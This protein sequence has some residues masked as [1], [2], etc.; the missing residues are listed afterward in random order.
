MAKFEGTNHSAI[1]NSLARTIADARP[2]LESEAMDLAL[3]I[4]P[5]PKQ[6]LT[7]DAQ[8]DIIGE[9][10]PWA[11]VRHPDMREVIADRL[12]RIAEV[13]NDHHMETSLVEKYTSAA[14]RLAHASSTREPI[15]DD[16][17]FAFA[18]DPLGLGPK[19][20]A[21]FLQPQRPSD[22]FSI[23]NRQED[24][25]MVGR[26]LAAVCSTGS[27]DLGVN[28][29]QEPL[30]S[31]MA[32]LVAATK[33]ATILKPI[34]EWF[35]NSDP[36]MCEV[37]QKRVFSLGGSPTLD[38]LGA[39]WGLSRER[40]RQI[41]VMAK[42]LIGLE[43]G[44]LL[45]EASSIFEPLMHK[46]FPLER[47]LTAT[48]LIGI[49]TT[50][51]DEVAGA[52]VWAAGPW[53][54]NDGWIYHKSLETVFRN[55]TLALRESVDPYG[56]VGEDISVL[57]NGFFVTD[58]DQRQYLEEVMGLVEISGY[59]STRD[60][61]RS[62]VA[63]ALMR[64]G[65]PATKGEIGLLAG[66]EEE[67]RVSSYLSMLPNIVRADKDRWAFTDWVDDAYDGIVGEIN[68]RID[69]NHGSVA[70]ASLLYELP[71][72]F[73]VSE[74]SVQA[75][76]QTSAY[77]VE[78]GFV[79]RAEYGFFEA[80]SPTKWP[81]AFQFQNLW[82]QRVRIEQRHFE[83]FSLKV[84]FDIAYANGLRPHCDLKV[85]LDGD[86]AL[87]S[88]IWRTHDVTRSIDVG[89]V[90]DALVARG[91]RPNDLILVCPSPT[92]VLLEKW[93]TVGHL[94]QDEPVV[95]EP[96]DHHDPLFDLLEGE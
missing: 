89:R 70:V 18:V 10:N 7:A 20:S 59:W 60:S 78:D 33:L 81:D 35:E 37:L 80:S 40:V 55:A 17:V 90:S 86:G 58:N 83:G 73:G 38:T 68:Q 66:I 32:F 93:E 84:R 82:G 45:R 43:C 31:S 44:P 63:A 39:P 23:T 94:D 22:D 72:R 3:G 79:R 1:R 36:R 41:E 53:V 16:D 95:Q 47:F 42:K 85:P 65:R 14:C 57:F 11:N 8:R 76:L 91:C 92:Q 9:L 62:R 19:T 21:E 12:L 96:L 52:L 28:L 15:S 88:V 5:W 46:V 87:V 2:Y 61:Q 34:N 51:G 29:G 50:R 49:S 56:L 69:A 26:I 13:L 6:K 74:L 25:R 30:G 54:C 77:V 75:F 67:S 27:L 71:E 48:R 4:H 64:I 24:F